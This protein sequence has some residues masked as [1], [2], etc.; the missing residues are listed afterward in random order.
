MKRKKFFYT[1]C[2]ILIFTFPLLG[3]KK[4]KNVGNQACFTC[5]DNMEKR[6]NR[7]PHNSMN[8]VG[9]ESCHGPGSIH[10]EDPSSENIFTFKKAAAI[11]IFKVCSACHK[12]MHSSYSSHMREGNSCLQC[13]NMWHSD[14][15]IQ[16]SEIPSLHLLRSTDDSLCFKCHKIQRGEFARPF[17]HQFTGSGN[18]CVSCHNPHMTKRELR[19]RRI[20][21]KCAK[22]HPDMAGPFVYVHL[23]TQHEGCMECHTPHGSTNPNLLTRSTTRFLCLSCHT[24]TS[25]THNQSDPKYRQCTSCHSAVHGSNISPKFFE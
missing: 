21:R 20:S 22:C 11:K 3:A 15:T 7:T 25:K 4:A 9:C 5:H 6:L 18:S 8:G 19:P 24:S 17:H 12:N 14:K 16:I 2:L 10:A 23:G 13:H 1:F